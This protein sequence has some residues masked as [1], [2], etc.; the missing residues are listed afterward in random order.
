MGFANTKRYT[1]ALLTGRNTHS[2]FRKIPGLA[3]TANCWVDIGMAAGNPPPNYYASEPLKAEVLDK[4]RGIFHGDDKSPAE[5]YLSELML[6]TPTAAMVGVYFLLDYVLYY[7]FVDLDDTDLQEFDNTTALPRYT[8]GANLRAMLVA[9]APTVGG[10]QCIFTYINQDGVEKTSPTNYLTTTGMNMGTLLTMQPA[11]AGGRG[12]FLILAPGDTGVQRIL[13]FT[14][15]ISNGG[16]GCL[17]L[18]KPLTTISIREINTP[19]EISIPV[20]RAGPPRIPDGAYLNF[21]CNP[22]GSIA[23]GLLTGRAQFLWT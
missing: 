21:I 18:V 6:V 12:P 1:D 20:M 14:N 8:D 10:G 11:S 23:A 22:A 4:W 2:H 15:L 19:V 17:V 5:K 7:P 16:L 9:Q 13:T 3:S